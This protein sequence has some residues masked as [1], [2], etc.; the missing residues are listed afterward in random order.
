MATGDEQDMAARLKAVL[1]S[2]WFARGVGTAPIKDA[3]LAG[4]GWM[5]AQGFALVNYVRRQGRVSSATD[6][7]LDIAARDYT[8]TSV[9]RRLQESDDSFRGRLLASLLPGGATRRALIQRLILLTGH[10]PVVFEPTQPM[11]TGAYGYGGL[12]YNVAGGYGSLS[13]PFQAFVSVRRPVSQGVPYLGGYNGNA[14]TPVYAPGGYNVGLMAYSNIA[15]AFDGV[16]DA[17]IYQMVAAV[18]PVG[19]TVWTRIHN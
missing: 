5:A 9:T 15:Q 19:S 10:A 11:D 8:G 6:V 2:A 1:P 17:D 7:F 12:G 4:I 3:V 14:S 18:Q 16:R 13:L